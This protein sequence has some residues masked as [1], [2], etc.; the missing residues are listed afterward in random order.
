VDTWWIQAHAVLS[1]SIDVLGIGATAMGVVGGTCMLDHLSSEKWRRPRL[2]FPRNQEVAAPQGGSLQVSNSH[3]DCCQPMSYRT[4]F[5]RNLY[6][7]PNNPGMRSLQDKKRSFC[8]LEQASSRVNLWLVA[9]VMNAAK[10]NSRRD[11]GNHAQDLVLE[12]IDP[13]NPE[14]ISKNR[15]I[16]IRNSLFAFVAAASVAAIVLLGLLLSK[17]DA[18]PA[19]TAPTYAIDDLMISLLPS[20][21]LDIAQSNASSPQAKAVAW[22]MNDSAFHEYD[23]YRI[24]QRYAL[25]VLYYSTSGELWTN[26]TGWLSSSNECA[27]YSSWQETDLL[28]NGPICQDESRFSILNLTKVGLIGTI[29]TEL[30]VLTDLTVMHLWARGNLSVALY[31]EL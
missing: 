23:R 29:P 11:L 18:S 30:E 9:R 8:Q 1:A 3:N 10:R 4:L 28:Y 13:I 24:L 14:D 22:L 7:C 6:Y 17:D 15:R 19:T 26:S 12:E 27:W 5:E 2:L 20:Y 16:L 31:S 21:S 25:A